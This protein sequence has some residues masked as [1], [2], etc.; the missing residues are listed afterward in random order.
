M[1][2]CHNSSGEILLPDFLLVGAAKSATSSLH[3]YLDQHPEIRMPS[4]KES[5][6]FSFVGNAP[7][8][9]SPGIL[10]DMVTELDDY[11][12]LFDGAV[13]EQKLGDASPS[14]LYTHE[15]TI[16]NIK[17]IYPEEALSRLRIIISLRDPV[18]RAFSQYL[19]MKRVLHEPLDFDGA[20]DAA[21]IEQRLSGQWNIFYD[22]TGFGRYYQQVKA[23]IDAFGRDKVMV[24]LYEDIC[25]DPVQTCQS[26]FR[27]IDV[28]AS[29]S[30][31][32]ETR[33]NSV[34]GEPRLK[35]LIRIL[36]SQ[37]SIKRRLV[38]CIPE[39]ARDLILN[40]MVK[41]M[42]KKTQVSAQTR[43]NLV[44]SYHDDIRQLE[45]LIDRDLGNWL[46]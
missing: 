20:I 22:Y 15:D 7:N 8:Y 19:T 26:I 33:H 41:P 23:F 40:S 38:S 25:A 14:Y 12:T 43:A 37:N 30:P 34:T 1:K 39:S 2:V 3:S 28:D 24:L 13:A 18:S 5:W 6:F 31:D 46:R 17:A 16:R 10:N 44:Q 4:V 11:V 42:L 45:T 21:T 35:W 27:F 32:V 36:K 9:T 29:F